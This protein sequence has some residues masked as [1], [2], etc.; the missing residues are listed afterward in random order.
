MNEHISRILQQINT[1]EDELRTVLHEQESRAL[2]T[3]RNKRVEFEHSVKEAHKQLKL[4]VFHWFRTSKPQNILSAPFVYGMI[5]PI[6][7]YD[8]FLGLYQTICFSLYGI[9]RVRRADYIVIDRHHLK[10]LNSIEKLNCMYCGY[11]NGVLAYARE[12][13]ARTEQYWCPIKHARKV[14]DSHR[15][16]VDFLGYGEAEQFQTFLE[17]SRQKLY[18]EATTLTPGLTPKQDSPRP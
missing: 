12:I 1:L 13:T 2:F 7:L 3:I 18:D 15:R 8:F 14:L 4:N 6:L 11:A 17:T 5:V 16:Y 10:Y 9:P